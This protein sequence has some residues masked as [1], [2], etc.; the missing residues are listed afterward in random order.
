MPPS[1]ARGRMRARP[2]PAPCPM[3]LLLIGPLCARALFHR[4]IIHSGSPKL[5]AR[6]IQH[7]SDGTSSPLACQSPARGPVQG[8][9]SASMLL[10]C[11]TETPSSTA[12]VASPLLG[13]GTTEG[14]VP[15]DGKRA[16]HTSSPSMHLPSDNVRK[17]STRLR[18]YTD[19]TDNCMVPSYKGR[20]TGRRRKGNLWNLRAR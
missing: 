10:T 3:L 9:T 14:A 12:C 8:G 20:Q 11:S 2:R 17:V 13:G 15:T 6:T 7:A 18:T 4:R 1:S 19:T 5:L 16:F